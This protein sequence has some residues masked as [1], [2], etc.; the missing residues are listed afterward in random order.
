MTL[1]VLAAV[2]FAAF[3]HAAWNT[4]LKVAGD[5][6][7]V[8][9]LMGAG[10]ALFAVCV[11][12]FVPSP[13][14]EI[15]PYLVASVAFHL[16]Y[17]LMLVSAYGHIDL[18][19]AYPMIRGSGPVL[20]TVVSA[21]VLGESVGIVGVV[22][23]A[24]VTAGVAA[25]GLGGRTRNVRALVFGLLGGALVATYT[26]LDGLAARISGAP[27]GY[28]M[29]LFV[30]TGIPLLCIAVVARGGRFIALAR[31]VAVRGIAAG[32]LAGMAFWI[33]IWALTQAPMGLVAAGR[34]TS[35]VL[36]ALASGWMLKE[37][38]NWLAIG[39]VFIGVALL[40][41]AGV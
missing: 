41:V 27:T 23:V 21:L 15:W 25:L 11:L 8:I 9:A 17:S 35:V 36:V 13:G 6:L 14:L 20:V 3:V 4:W 12:P 37:R 39:A 19:V 24:L 34:E 7:V 30:L 5:R 40:R 28:A 2:L 26:L 16:G 10:W 1:Q 38:V 22:A 32:A 29:W 18:S 33:V 31:P